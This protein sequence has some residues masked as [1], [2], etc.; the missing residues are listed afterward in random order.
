[1]N[2]CCCSTAF[3]NLCPASS[4]SVVES[5]HVLLYFCYI[6]TYNYTDLH[7]ECNE[8]NECICFCMVS[9]VNI[10][11]ILHFIENVV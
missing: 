8:I 5:L 2:V 4:L 7:I 11:K 1:M 9:K 3:F 10:E 6:D